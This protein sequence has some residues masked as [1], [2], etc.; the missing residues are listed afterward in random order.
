M[1]GNDA[2]SPE[3]EHE[4]FEQGLIGSQP[5]GLEAFVGVLRRAFVIQARFPHG[6][7]DDPVAREVDGV[8]I[9][10][11]HGGH[12]P[13]GKRMVQRITGA[14]AFKGRHELRLALLETAQHGIGNLAVHLD[15]PFTGKGEGVW[16]FGG[17]GVA[18]QAAKDVSEEIRQQ[19]GFL[20]VV[21]AAGSDE[22]GPVQEFGL[23]VPHALR[24]G[25]RPYL[26][27][28]DFGVEERFG[29]ERHLPGDKLCAWREKTKRI[30]H[31]TS[32]SGAGAS[33]RLP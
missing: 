31:P 19:G 1:R 9:G 25:E 23:P 13:P 4:A 12:A 30:E 32:I 27:A 2:F 28:Q 24:Q 7:D 11:V 20:E 17:T 33:P 29:F 10:L 8:A 18:Q 16:R 3:Q 21:R 5:D 15:V 14:L 6:G 22:S 26:L